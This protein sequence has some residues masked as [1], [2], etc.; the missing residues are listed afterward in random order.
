MEG[1][2]QF[3]GYIENRDLGDGLKRQ[4]GKKKKIGQGLLI[5]QFVKRKSAKKAEGSK[6]RLESQVFEVGRQGEAEAKEEQAR[7]QSA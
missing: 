5:S 4:S 2:A 3:G 7:D 6:K 1:T